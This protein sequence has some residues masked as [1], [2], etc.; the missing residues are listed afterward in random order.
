MINGAT[1]F[2]SWQQFL[3][4]AFVAVVVMPIIEHYYNKYKDKSNN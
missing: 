4:F 1:F 3:F 2:M